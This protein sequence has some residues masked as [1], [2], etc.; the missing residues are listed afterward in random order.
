MPRLV[1][2]LILLNWAIP[3]LVP[4]CASVFVSEG[5]DIFWERHGLGPILRRIALSQVGA[6]V[7]VGFTAVALDAQRRVARP[8]LLPLLLGA[9]SA[10]VVVL[11]GHADP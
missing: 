11:F 1:T 7:L 3:F 9:V 10:F 4:A 2:A 5:R 8:L 6:Q